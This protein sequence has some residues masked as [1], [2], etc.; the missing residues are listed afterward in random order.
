[1]LSKPPSAFGISEHWRLL[2][3]V[4]HALPSM[5]RGPKECLAVSDI[6]VRH[7]SV[8]LWGTG[9]SPRAHRGYPQ[10]DCRCSMARER[11]SILHI[12]SNIIAY[13][14]H[15]PGKCKGILRTSISFVCVSI[16]HHNFF[17]VFVDTYLIP[18]PKIVT[19]HR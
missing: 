5:I 7:V 1:M 13:W 4:L 14:Y 16:H 19:N 6:T 2:Y 8:L 11:Q 12:N 9:S 17:R 3:Y 10:P 15:I 18:A